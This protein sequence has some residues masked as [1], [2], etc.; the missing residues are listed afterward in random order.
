MIASIYSSVYKF[1]HASGI[2]NKLKVVNKFS[3]YSSMLT[4]PYTVKLMVPS[5]VL[6]IVYEK[7]SPIQYLYKTTVTE[8]EI[9]M[10]VLFADM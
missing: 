8:D 3:I 5:S 7:F 4:I 1:V 10:P 9:L 6:N 2:M